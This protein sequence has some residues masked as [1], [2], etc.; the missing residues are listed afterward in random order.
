MPNKAD[1]IVH[2]MAHIAVWDV[3][4]LLLQEFFIL[5]GWKYEKGSPPIPPKKVIMPDS[6]DSPSEDFANSVELYYKDPKLL[7]KFNP[8]SFLILEKI[9]NSKEKQQ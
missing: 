6:G 3:S 1:I 4:P 7:K 5:R 2:E 8:K 9:I